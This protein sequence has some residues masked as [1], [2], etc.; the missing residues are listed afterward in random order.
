MSR[1]P[2][3]RC[4]ICESDQCVDFLDVPNVP[5]TVGS[6]CQDRGRALLASKGDL[7]LCFCRGCTYIWNRAYQRGKH[8]YVPGYEISLHFSPT[9]QQFL[10][11]VADR[12][13][14]DYQLHGKTVLEIACGSGHFLRMLCKRGVS[15]AIGIDPVLQREGVEKIGSSQITFRREL[16]SHRHA[17]LEAD[18][19]C[20]RQALHAIPSPEELVRVV[21]AAI[22][23]GKRTPVYFEVVN[24]ASLFKSQIIWQLIY[25]Y[26]S[27]FTP[28]SL[29]RLFERCGFDV[30]RSQ[31]CFVA[32]QYL[33]LEAFPSSESRHWTEHASCGRQLELSD[34][35][36]FASTFREKIESWREQLSQLARSGR[37]VLAWGAGGRGTNFLNFVNVTQQEIPY[38]VDINPTRQGGFIAGTGQ[39]VVAPGFL[40]EYRPDVLVLTNP[41][42]ANEVRKQMSEM[43]VDCDLLLA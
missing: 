15:Q 12:L 27:F 34:V 33:E 9:Y 4:P 30:V 31:P 29:T 7:K 2:Q 39:L 17:H 19:I 24:A 43:G 3:I 6:L 5:V 32:G 21:R 37:R 13:V 41:T 18:F 10:D 23:E 35:V 28:E 40:R 36:A 11:E 42:Y 20:C 38:I 8:E 25:E 22:G 14:R 16:Y 1:L 26:Y